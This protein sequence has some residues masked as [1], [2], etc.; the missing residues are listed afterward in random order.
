M[1]QGKIKL[2]MIQRIR[3]TP[4]FFALLILINTIFMVN[5]YGQSKTTKIPKKAIYKGE[6]KELTF[7]QLSDAFLI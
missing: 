4:I 2:I 1:T 7:Q 6:R 3:S 5:I